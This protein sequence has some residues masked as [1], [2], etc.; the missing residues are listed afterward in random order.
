MISTIKRVLPPKSANLLLN[1]KNKLCKFIKITPTSFYL[2]LDVAHCALKCSLCPNGG[3]CVLE[4]PGKGFMNLTLFKRIVDKFVK[5]NI[6]VNH[7]EIGNWGE[8]LLNP[9]I[10][11]IIR[12]AKSHPRFMQRGAE[13]SVNTT[14][15]HLSKPIAF[16]KSGVDIIRITISGM[17]QEIYSRYHNGGNIEKVKSNILKLVQVRN[18]EKLENL[19][20]SLV[21]LNFTYNKKDSELAEEFCRE[22]GINFISNRGRMLCVDCNIEFQKQKERMSKIYRQFIDLQEER[23]WMTTMDSNNVKF[24]NLRF[25]RVTVN[26]DGQLFRCCGVFDKRHFLGSIFDFKIKDIPEA[27]SKICI[28]CAETPISNGRGIVLF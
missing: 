23:S 24:C 11:Q 6:F 27:E 18:S 14:L 1:V 7:I 17:T 19:N 8:P 21:F 25:N 22:H 3:I 4:G 26:F 20:L 28:I 15:N 9:D 2:N 16:L 12:Y 13:V 5:E 10:H